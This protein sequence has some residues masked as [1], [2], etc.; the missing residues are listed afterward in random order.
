MLI[1]GS[2]FL[3]GFLLPVR[4]DS[5][6][7]QKAGKAFCPAAA[8]FPCPS[9]GFAAGFRFS[10]AAKTTKEHELFSN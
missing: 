3:P 4:F 7:R 6:G 2:L 10:S 9:A 8:D 1:C 5:T